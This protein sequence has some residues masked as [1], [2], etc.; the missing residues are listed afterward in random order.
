M[1]SAIGEVAAVGL[2]FMGGTILLSLF[3]TTW[4]VRASVRGKCVAVFIEPNREVRSKL[5]KV[6]NA[7][8][9]T[10]GPGSIPEMYMIGS[11]KSLWKHWPDGCPGF[12]QEPVPCHIFLRNKCEP[13]DLFSEESLVTAASLQYMLDEGMLRQTW[14]E[15]KDAASGFDAL[16]NRDWLP[17]IIAGVSLMLVCATLYMVWQMANDV[18]DLSASLG[19]FSG[20]GD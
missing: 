6:K 16:K 17:V 11:Q 13:I 15:A 14:K 10:K 9:E 7:R 5:L 19:D 4:W 8:L 2:I 12:L 18:G 3:G 1:W 20:G